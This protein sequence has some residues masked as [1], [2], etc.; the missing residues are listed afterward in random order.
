LRF[1]QVLQIVIPPL[2]KSLQKGR[3]SLN[4]E[5]EVEEQP[6]ND[7]IGLMT[8]SIFAPDQYF[9][10]FYLKNIPGCIAGSKESFILNNPTYRL[11][12]KK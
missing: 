7:C 12:G 4:H 5:N 11:T 9:S 6:P 1:R 10:G 2:S 8:C 3:S